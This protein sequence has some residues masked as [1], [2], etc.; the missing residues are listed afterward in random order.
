MQNKPCLKYISAVIFLVMSWHTLFSQNRQEMPATDR[1]KQQFG[2]GLFSLD[3]YFFKSKNEADNSR[4]EVYVAFANDILQFVKERQGDFSARYELL[5]TVFDKKMN[6]IGEQSET[7]ELNAK[8]FASTNDRR[9][10]NRHH[11]IFDLLPG[12]YKLVL[13]LTDHDTQKALKREVNIDEK[14]FITS[15]SLLSDVIFADNIVVGSNEYIEG[16]R[17]NLER[18]FTAPDS[19]FWAVFEIYPK[20]LQDSLT[21]QYSVIDMNSH[22]LAQQMIKLLPDRTIVQYLIDLSKYVKSSGNYFLVIQLSQKEHQSKKRVKFSTNWSSEQFLKVNVD[23]GLKILK[24]FIPAKDYKELKEASD[25]IKIDYFNDFWKKR[26]PTPGSKEN[27]L[28]DEFY[29]RVNF[30]N[31]YFSVN[32]LD[33]DGC[34]TDRGAIYIKYGPPTEVER[35]L[36]EISLPPYEIWYYE[37]IKRR[38]FFEDRS[39]I[40]NFR[41]VRME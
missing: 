16:I 18:K 27:E 9:L 11:F 35:H 37:N 28:L 30:T 31:N 39:G 3:S 7:R 15:E 19:S 38:F 24:D 4:L 26:D 22:P 17:P 25:S 21:L 13:Q 23:V 40:G 32:A 12:N 41:L 29:R 6:L 1:S 2:P 33:L 10:N 34:D 5:A 8:N 14:S 36:D 20:N